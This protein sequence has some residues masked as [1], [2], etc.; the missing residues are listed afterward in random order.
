MPT[1]APVGGGTT[2]NTSTPSFDGSTD[3]AY[4]ISYPGG[5]AAGFTGNELAYMYF[6][7]LHNL[8]AVKPDGTPQAGAG[9]VNV[10]FVDAATGQTDSF[11]NLPGPEGYWTN[12][13]GAPPY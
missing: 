1:L 10:S 13:S 6:V 3:Y 4:N 9:L 12:H 7:N 2:F 5:A 11:L 8:A